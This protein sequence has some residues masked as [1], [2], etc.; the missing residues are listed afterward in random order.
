M[1]DLTAGEI[2]GS[3]LTFSP[4]IPHGR[5]LKLAERGVRNGH[6]DFLDWVSAAFK[7]SYD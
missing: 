5:G 1:N 4:F 3:I 6:I 2:L 7:W